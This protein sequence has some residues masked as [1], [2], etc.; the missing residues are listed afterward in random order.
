MKQK[1]GNLI[2]IIIVLSLLVCG[3]VGYIVCD[4]LF[5]NEDTNRDGEVLSDL[6][7]L[8]IA[9]NQIKKY[10]EYNHSLGVYCGE[11]DQDD[12]IEFGSY[13]NGDYRDYNASKIFKSINE[14]KNY[15]VSFMV[16]GL[17]PTY[18]NDGKSYLEQNGKLY[19]QLPHKGGA[20]RY[21]ESD[22]K[23]EITSITSNSIVLKV[24]LVSDVMANMQNKREG[25]VKLVK[26]S[27]GNWLV[28]EYNVDIVLS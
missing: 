8:S 9:K 24:S 2:V 19:C 17:Y 25:T 6:E 26:N 16:E 21:N 20:D 15:L 27:V 28:S 1:N 18:L 10:F 7:A 12:Y 3:L 23:Y 11:Y 4:K 22:S 5:D 13:E 14:L